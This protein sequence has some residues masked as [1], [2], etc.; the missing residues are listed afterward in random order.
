MKNPILKHPL[1]LIA[2]FFL[3]L[4]IFSRFGLKL[5]ISVISQ[6]KGQPLVVDG[7]GKVMAVPDTAKVTVGIEESGISL[8]DVQ[9]RASTK[10]KTLVDTLKKLGIDDKQIKTTSYNVFPEYNYESGSPRITGYKVSSSYE[11]TVKDFD[12]VNDVL[13]EAVNAGAKVV[14]GI[15]F[16]VNEETEKKLLTQ[17]REE[18]VAEARQKAESLAKAAGVFLG[19]ILNISESQYTPGAVPIALKE[20]GIGGAEP[21]PQ[22][23]ITP[24]ETEISV[25]VS[26]S[27]EIR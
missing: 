15:T 6:E 9:K 10:S 23:E 11:V 22:P 13:V 5:P 21:Q 1:T 27:F 3:L 26:I 19:K 20:A 4:A 16:E 18:A 8:K 17:A 14:G 25:V 12:K 7:E 24:G 2:A